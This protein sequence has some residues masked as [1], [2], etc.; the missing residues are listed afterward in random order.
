MS[1]N[2]KTSHFIGGKVYGK[3][4]NERKRPIFST[5]RRGWWAASGKIGGPHQAR[6]VGSWEASHKIVG[7]TR[8]KPEPRHR[9]RAVRRWRSRRGRRPPPNSAAL[10]PAARARRTRAAGRR[11][12]AGAAG[13]AR[14]WP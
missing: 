13:A 2:H 11:A 8:L 14:R 7:G 9:A 5:R 12:G 3:G 10:R 4:P 6:Y 1:V